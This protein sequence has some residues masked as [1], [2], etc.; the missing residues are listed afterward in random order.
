MDNQFGRVFKEIRQKKGF[1]ARDVAEGIVSVQ[2]LRRFEKDEADIRL[3][4]FYELLKKINLSFE[5]YMYLCHENTLDRALNELDA[6]LDRAILTGDSILLVNLMK[7]YERNYK[8]TGEIR[9][10]HFNI[11]CRIYYNRLFHPSFEIDR[12]IILSYL[13]RCETWTKYEFFIANHAIHTFDME[14]LCNLTI[15]ALNNKHGS[16][17]LHHFALDFCF[18]AAA[19]LISNNR[20]DDARNVLHH[21]YNN[22]SVKKILPQLSFNIAMRFLEG[23]LLV[24]KGEDE[25]HRICNEIIDFYMN[26]IGYEEYANS[27]HRYYVSM[28]TRS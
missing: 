8:E 10:L 6:N 17:K 28:S 5:D 27:I 12:S 20:D 2:F 7:E 22:T 21:Y 23:I 15:M 3:S 9:F 14:A 1:K 4:N 26:T 16:R 19:A 25:G 13:D 11:I 18:H 24:K